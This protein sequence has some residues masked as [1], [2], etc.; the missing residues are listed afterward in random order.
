MAVGYKHPR[1]TRAALNAKAAA[2]TIEPQ[3]VYFI[4]DEARLAVGLSNNSYQAFLKE[5][6]GGGGGG[7]GSAITGFVV[8]FTGTGATQNVTIPSASSATE[9]M[10]FFGAARQLSNSYTVSGTTVTVIAPLNVACEIVK[11][12]GFKG[13]TGPSGANGTNGTNGTVDTIGEYTNGANPTTPTS[14]LRV[15]ARRNSGRNRLAY[16]GPAGI[17]VSVQAFLGANKI[18]YWGAQGNSN[19]AFNNAAPGIMLFNF[20]HAA[21]GTATTR[22]VANTNMFTLSRR[23][24]FTSAATAGASAGTRNNA[25]QFSRN[26]GYEYVA[27]FGISQV[28]AT[29]R[30]FAGMCHFGSAVMANS[31]PST[32]TSI[33]V[34]TVSGQ[35]TLHFMYGNQQQVNLGA[36]FPVNTQNVDLY[37]ARLF[38]IPGSNTTNWSVTRLNTG[39][40]AEGSYTDNT[41]Y[42]GPAALGSPQIWIN[43]GSTASAVSVDVISQYIE[44]DT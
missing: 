33:G 29:T 21:T 15:F 31:E 28:N 41:G 9:I 36:N 43:N 44:T 42:I 1:G 10:V 7:G 6:E 14:G 19:T 11:L 22:N 13:D 30:L 3:Q 18:G 37:E 39:H 27:R 26:G 24:G 23:M 2:G 35:T 34:G 16:I 12:P 17:D 5:G 25:M 8:P 40:Y 4:T 38:A 32:Q 20:G